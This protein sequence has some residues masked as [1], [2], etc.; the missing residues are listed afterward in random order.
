[1][2]AKQVKGDVEIETSFAELRVE[3]VEGN[4]DLKDQNGQVNAHNVTGKVRASTSFS[5]IDI[6]GSGTE[7]VCHN[8]NGGI[9]LRVRSSAV[10]LVEARTSFGSLE[11]QLPADLKPVI[12]AHTSF[13]DIDS[14]FPVVLK[15]HGEDAFAGLEA[16]VPRVS[17]ENQN[18][19]IHIQSERFSSP[20]P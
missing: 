15:A 2:A 17:L 1:V 12:R 18:G 8:Q 9:S 11:V 4:V 7:F 3:G 6:D 5:R 16:G 14:D 20:S 19:R 10:S 13:G